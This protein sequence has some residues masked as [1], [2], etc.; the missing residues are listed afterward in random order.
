[1]AQAFDIT[2]HE[3]DAGQRVDVV[4]A[5]TLQA[6]QGP[7]APSYSRARIQALIRAGGVRYK[8][9]T[10]RASS[11]THLGQTLAVTVPEPVSSALHPVPMPLCVMFEDAHL[12]VLNK[13]QGLV[14]HPGAGTHAP[15]LVH[16]LLAHCTDLSGIGGVLR[17]GI[18]HR[19]DAGTSGLMVVAKTDASHRELARQF[20][21]REVTKRYWALVQGTLPEGPKGALTTGRIDTLYAR[22]PKFRRRM[23]AARA[24]GPN[25]RRAVTLWRVVGSDGVLHLMD[26]ALKTGRTHQIRVHMS[27]MGCP[28]VGDATYGRPGSTFAG[29]E[30]LAGLAHQ[31]LHAYGLRFVHPVTKKQH[32]YTAEVPQAWRN[33]AQRLTASRRESCLV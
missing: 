31:A 23:T 8:A 4:L 9:A 5:R 22:D 2:I 16:G 28:I 15:T 24:T 17:P 19:L 13:P 1:M 33:A 29:H 26:V 30:D 32:T 11:R 21:E 25:A 7:G 12:L 6:H 18:V 10:V 20:A 27:E 14:V 3:H